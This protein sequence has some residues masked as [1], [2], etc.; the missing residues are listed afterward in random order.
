MMQLYRQYSADD[1]EEVIVVG[2][3]RAGVSWSSAFTVSI[4]HP[5]RGI[6][7]QQ[8]PSSLL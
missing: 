7:E 8:A 1:F 3:P 2:P 5:Y 4:F 6:T